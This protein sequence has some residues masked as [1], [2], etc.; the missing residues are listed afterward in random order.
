MSCP[1]LNGLFSR[2]RCEDEDGDEDEVQSLW[3]R[4]Q[5]QVTCLM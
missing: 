2:T 1:I 4:V 5:G 3:F